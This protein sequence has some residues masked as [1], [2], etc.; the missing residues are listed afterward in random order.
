MVINLAK[1]SHFSNST[2]QVTAA[3]GNTVAQLAYMVEAGS[4]VTSFSSGWVLKVST[5]TLQR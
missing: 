1:T 4:Q 2:M 5:R 3:S